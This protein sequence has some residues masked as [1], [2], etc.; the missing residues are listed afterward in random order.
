MVLVFEGKIAGRLFIMTRK[1]STKLDV[2]GTMINPLDYDS[3]VKRIVQSSLGNRNLSIAPIASHPVVESFFNR[4]LQFTLNRFDLVL[5]DGQPVVHAMNF[6][7]GAAMEKRVYGPRLLLETVEAARENGLKILLYGN[8]TEKL[9]KVLEAKYK[10]LT[11]VAF[12]DLKQ[13]KVDGKMT[14]LLVSSLKKYR[15]AV[16]FL[17]VGSPTQHFLLSKLNKV[18]MPVVAVGSAF[19]FIAKIKK[20][21]PDWMGDAG[22][23]WL[24]RL[25]QEPSRLWRR[26]LVY[27]FVFIFLVLMQKAGLIKS[28][29]TSDMR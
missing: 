26:Y 27:G 11:V 16:L 24:F 14:D 13:A 2:I 6:L 9:K 19:D 7:H 17:G 20:Q 10:K 23:E 21:A 22:L 1:K 25:A 29:S 28:H 12:P 15:K 3:T 4:N 5:P 18:K 8:N